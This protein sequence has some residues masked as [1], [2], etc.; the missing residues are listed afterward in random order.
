MDTA[1]LLTQRLHQFVDGAVEI[2]VGAA[3]LVDLADGV[4]DGGVV[5]AAELASDLGERRLGQLLGEVHRDL[6]RDDDLPG[7]VLL[8][9]LGDAHGEVLGHGALDGLDGDLADLCV[10]E[11]LEALLRDGERD[12]DAVHRAP[13]DEPHQCAFELADVG[14]Y[15]RRDEERYVGGELRVLALRLLLQDGDL[16]LEIGWLNVGDE[17][18][19]EARAQTVFKIC[20]L[21]RR[22]GPM[23]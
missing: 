2:F 18:P 21:F 5:L 9:E 14:A 4:H 1:D 8:L 12:L 17:S 10:D 6:A 23:R 19:L 20:E 15:V 22:A 11:L 16:G 7:V 13:G 3:L